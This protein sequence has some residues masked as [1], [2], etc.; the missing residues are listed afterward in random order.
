M[1]TLAP[2]WNW[3]FRVWVPM[4]SRCNYTH[5]AHIFTWIN[6]LLCPHSGMAPEVSACTNVDYFEP[7]SSGS[8]CTTLSLSPARWFS[9]APSRLQIANYTK[10]VDRIPHGVLLENTGVVTW[11]F[12]FCKAPWYKYWH[13]YAFYKN[14]N[15]ASLSAVNNN[16]RAS[17]N[18]IDLTRTI[19]RS[20]KHFT[21]APIKSVWKFC[22][23]NNG[24]FY[25]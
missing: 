17:T 8:C 16:I 19:I 24:V 15:A 22:V 2:K 6:A 14:A 21:V 25:K 9:V 12:Q 3:R 20:V 1:E 7:K 10:R 23:C 5:D 18:R 11:F 13:N 4:T